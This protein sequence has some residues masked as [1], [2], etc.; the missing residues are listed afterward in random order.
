MVLPM[1]TGAEAVESAIKVARK[2]AYEVKGVA[3]DRATIVVAADNF[4]GRTTT[5][6]KPLH[7]RD[8]ARRLRPLHPGLPRRPG[9][10]PRRAGSGRR[11]DHRGRADRAHPGRGGRPRHPGRRLP[12]GCPGADPARRLSVHRGRDPVRP[13][14][15]PAPHS[16]WNTRTSSPTCSSWARRSAAASCRCR[17]WSACGMCSGCCDPVSTA[18]PSAAIRWPRRSAP[19]SSDSWR[20]VNTRAGRPSWACRSGLTALVGRGVEGFRSRGLWAG[21][22]I[23]PAIG[24]G[25]EISEGLMREGVLVKDTHGSTIRLAPPL[26]IT[27]EELHSALGA[28]EKVL[29]QGVYGAGGRL[30]LGGHAALS[31]RP[32]PRNDCGST[33]CGP[34]T[35]A[36]PRPGPR[37]RTWSPRP[38][39]AARSCPRP[40]PGRAGESTPT[41]FPARRRPTAP[42]ASR[43][44]GRPVAH[45]RQYSA[46]SGAVG[47]SEFAVQRFA[48]GGG[49]QVHSGDLADVPRTSRAGSA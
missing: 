19:R 46:G 4:H 39:R 30:R 37:W 32:S 8:G 45:G 6:V 41:T 7:G 49:V 3:P 40:Q 44:H 38:G 24:T 12:D 27:C 15:A 11:R 13:G 21:V 5:I 36:W 34:K 10:R 25:R 43:R 17:R 22:D 47:E 16:P 14:A 23:D 28:L 1:N 31:L 20:P 35:R 2:W 42:P 9:Q 48:L 33:D 18:R 29:S 26:T